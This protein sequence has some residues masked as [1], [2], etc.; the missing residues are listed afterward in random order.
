MRPKS[1]GLVTLTL[2]IAVLTAIGFA[3][4]GTPA[5]RPCRSFDTIEPTIG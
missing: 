2:T 3:Q 4:Q 5:P 1:F